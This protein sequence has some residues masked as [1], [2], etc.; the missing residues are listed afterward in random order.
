MVLNTPRYAGIESAKDDTGWNSLGKTWKQPEM[1]KV[2]QMEYTKLAQN[3]RLWNAR[4][5]K[6]GR[7]YI[8]MVD[9]SG[10]LVK[11]VHQSFEG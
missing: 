3:V 9:R 2:E 6:L 1:Q 8:N 10:L 4:S 11:W 7:K 5:N